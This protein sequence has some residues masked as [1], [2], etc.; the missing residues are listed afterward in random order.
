MA[1]ATAGSKSAVRN[2]TLRRPTA[3]LVR[4]FFTIWSETEADRIDAVSFTRRRRPIGKDV[5]LVG[6]AACADD[7]GANHA[8]AGVADRLQM[9]LGERLRE[10][11]PAGAALE[12]G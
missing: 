10:A 4:Q 3:E 12:F 2:F 6:A 9:I 7:L 1:A 5:S 8:V 11:R